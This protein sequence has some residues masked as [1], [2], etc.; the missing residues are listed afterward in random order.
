M[1][2]GYIDHTKFQ[3]AVLSAVVSYVIEGCIEASSLPNAE[4]KDRLP[5]PPEKSLDIHNST[6]CQ[7]YLAQGKR[8]TFQRTRGLVITLSAQLQP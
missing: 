8:L 5:G 4:P 7:E 1:L 3:P 2:Y 6:Q